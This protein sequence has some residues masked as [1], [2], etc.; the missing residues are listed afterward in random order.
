MKLKI[1]KQYSGSNQETLEQLLFLAQPLFLFS[2][3]YVIMPKYKMKCLKHTESISGYFN[4]KKKSISGL[5]DLQ[6]IQRA[7]AG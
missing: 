3:I 1:A 5:F 6:C 7:K 2:S 4:I